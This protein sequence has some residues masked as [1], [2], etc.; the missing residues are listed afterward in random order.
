M[1]RK[2]KDGRYD[3]RY[4]GGSALNNRPLSNSVMVFTLYVIFIPTS[5][6][7]FYIIPMPYNYIVAGFLL[8][9]PITQT[10]WWLQRQLSKTTDSLK[11]LEDIYNDI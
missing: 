2:R 11:S 8:L 5:I 9:S 6:V 3:E 4:K 1:S 10:N 7:L